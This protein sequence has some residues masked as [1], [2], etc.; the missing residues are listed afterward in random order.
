MQRLVV[1]LALLISGCAN[2][3]DTTPASKSERFGCAT[4]TALPRQQRLQIG[5]WRH[6]E[7]IRVVNG[8]PLAS[9]HQSGH[10]VVH[11]YCNGTWEFTSR[12]IRSG[13]T[14]NWVDDSHIEENIVYSNLAL[15]IGLSSV[16]GITVDETN[17]ELQVRQT[18]EQRAQVLPPPR[19]GA[20]HVDFDTLVITRFERVSVGGD[21]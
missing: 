2:S 5:A 14:F 15:Q 21:R 11:Y 8:T 10:G 3:P 12:S 4:S 17:L 16:K 19:P 1:A 20:R 18:A 7:L 9:Q 13:G 6:V